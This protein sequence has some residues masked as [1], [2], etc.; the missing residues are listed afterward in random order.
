MNTSIHPFPGFSDT[1][2]HYEI[3]DGLRGVAA[4]I[5][6]IFHLLETFS[7][8]NNLNQIVNHGYLA[9]EEAFAFIKDMQ[10]RNL[11]VPVV[12]DFAGPKAI[13]AVGDYL[14]A[15]GA[16][17]GA[18]YLSNVEDYLY[19]SGRW[20]A[21]CRNVAALPLDPSSTFI[22]STN[23]GSF[24]RG[25]GFVLSLGQMTEEVRTCR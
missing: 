23:A 5:V 15:Q 8:G 10:L 24:G 14:R 7:G 11:I 16:T 21:F 4:V 2:N 1:K 12:G 18:F 3:L 17:V 22:R 19:P 20:E 25:G 6:V 9:T 13:R